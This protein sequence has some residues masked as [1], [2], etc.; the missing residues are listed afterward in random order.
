MKISLKISWKLLI[1]F[2]SL[3]GLTVA[4]GVVSYMSLGQIAHASDFN[5][6]VNLIVKDMLEARRH[7]KNYVIRGDTSEIDA[8]HKLVQEIIDEATETKKKSSDQT[9]IQQLDSIINQTRMYKTAFD[10]LVSI[11][12]QQAKAD[13]EMVNSARAVLNKA[14]EMNLTNIYV[15][16]LECRIAEKNYIIR[17][18]SQYIT[19]VHKKIEEILSMTQENTI[20]AFVNEYKE[21]FDEYVSLVAQKEQA[22]EAMVEAGRKILGSK[23]VG[24]AYYGGAELLQAMVHAQ[25]ESLQYSTNMMVIA[26]VGVSSGTGVALAFIITRSITKPLSGLIADTKII[27]EGNLAHEIQVKDRKD[28]I[29]DVINAVK[30]MVHNTAE[31]VRKVKAAAELVSSMSQEVSATAQ[32]VNAGM[33]QVSTATQQISQGAQKLSQLAQQ[34]AQHANTLFAALQQT[35]SNTEKSVQIGKESVEIMNQIQE[36]SKKA[37]ESIE[38]IQNSMETTAQTVNGMYT[39]LAK[40]GELANLVT[41]VA[42]QTEML[43]LNAAIEAARAGEAGRGFAVVADAVKELSDQSGQ[44]A[45]E[46][47]QSVTQVQAKGKEALDVAGKLSAQA[48]EGIQVVRTTIEGTKGVA[49]LIQKVNQM[50]SEVT[51]GVKKGVQS[52]EEVVKIV[53]E[54]SQISQESA[55]ACEENSAAIEQQTASMNQL[56]T[57]AQKLSEVSMQLRK[58]IDKFKV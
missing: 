52:V 14:E 33:E 8:V 19:A 50:L 24:N 1:G 25:M 31:L 13:T 3:V 15:Q 55:S 7:E 38:Q 26:F 4:I 48:K 32:Q 12:E 40:I 58:E 22:D 23:E 45:K 44:A 46:T 11:T 37:M 34:A 5:D 9:I 16:M 42:S 20:I 47:L 39:A 43:A 21:N 10:T 56:A 2:M 51:S 30:T 17:G 57:S 36:E 35:G 53:D 18:D 41:D 27:A 54:V 29:G 28:E 49:D 6:H